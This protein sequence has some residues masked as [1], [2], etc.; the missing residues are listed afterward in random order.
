[1]YVDIP[2]KAADTLAAIHLPWVTPNEIR[3]NLESMKWHPDNA[4]ELAPV[5]VEMYN[6]AFRKGMEVALRSVT[7]ADNKLMLTLPD[8]SIALYVH[9]NPQN[10]T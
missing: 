4:A 3:H 9:E 6:G 10:A 2:Q 7:L 1:M 8:G 5:I